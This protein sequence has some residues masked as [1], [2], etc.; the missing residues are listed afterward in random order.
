M[1]QTAYLSNAINRSLDDDALERRAEFSATRT[2]GFAS[3]ALDA[4]ERIPEHMAVTKAA[5][6]FL[7]WMIEP[8]REPGDTVP[9]WFAKG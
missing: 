6:E 8:L 3:D 7:G 9:D 2:I 4:S 5:N 1:V